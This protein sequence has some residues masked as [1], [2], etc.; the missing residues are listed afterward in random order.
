MLVNYENTP[1]AAESGLSSE[2]W[3]PGTS[4]RPTEQ[5][6]IIERDYKRLN[7]QGPKENSGH[8]LERAMGENGTLG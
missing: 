8:T 6:A 4:V 7:S 5:E 2:P 3:E 1:L